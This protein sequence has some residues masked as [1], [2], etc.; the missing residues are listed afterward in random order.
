[1]WFRKVLQT[2]DDK[3]LSVSRLV[4]GLIFFAHGAQKVFGWF[5]GQGFDQTMRS[6]TQGM[7]IPAAFAVM[8]IAAEFLG[9]I[10]LVLGLLT[11]VAAFAI[12]VNMAVAVFLV[13]ARNGLFMNWAHSQQGE[14]FEYHLLALAIVLLLVIRGGG[15]WSLDRLLEAWLTGGRTLQIHFEPR[16]SR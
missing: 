12:G 7:G 14:G 9:G 4:L 6:F 8:A 13:H 2:A 16:P 10:S 3:V 11:R 1:M 5:G 15:A